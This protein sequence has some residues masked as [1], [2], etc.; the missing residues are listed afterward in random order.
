MTRYSLGT[1]TWIRGSLGDQLGNCCTKYVIIQGVT[2]PY[3]FL[4]RIRMDTQIRL[5]IRVEKH[6]FILGDEVLMPGHNSF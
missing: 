4:C 5:T 1:P 6:A 2:A 3:M